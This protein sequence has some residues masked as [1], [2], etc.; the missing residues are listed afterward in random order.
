MKTEAVNLSL[1]GGEQTTYIVQRSADAFP[2]MPCDVV[3]IDSFFYPL[4]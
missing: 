1:D 3:S 4:I 2:F